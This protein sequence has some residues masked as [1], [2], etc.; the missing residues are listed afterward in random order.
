MLGEGFI[1]SADCKGIFLVI[2]LYEL[3]CIKVCK[4]F[5]TVMC[6]GKPFPSD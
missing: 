1:G 4:G 3:V 2:F 6:L 5:P